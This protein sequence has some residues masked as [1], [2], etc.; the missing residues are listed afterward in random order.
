[1]VLKKERAKAAAR[2][3]S[4]AVMEEGFIF[5]S[6][7]FTGWRGLSRIGARVDRGIGENR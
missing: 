7:V 1:V 5:P 4:R 6:G 2:T 3:S